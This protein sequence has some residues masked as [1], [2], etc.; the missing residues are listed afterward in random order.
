MLTSIKI[1]R[2]HLAWDNPEQDLR[3]QFET[4]KKK[5]GLT[6]YRRLGVY[7]LT[8]YNSTRE[9]DLER[10]YFLRELGYDP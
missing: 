7:V 6:D 3:P 4:F 8:N 9:Q 10:V 1:K 5:N 2:L